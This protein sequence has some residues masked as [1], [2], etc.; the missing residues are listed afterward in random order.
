MLV[1]SCHF[2]FVMV[3]VVILGLADVRSAKPSALRRSLLLFLLPIVILLR[4][5]ALIGAGVLQRGEANHQLAFNQPDSPDALRVVEFVNHLLSPF[6]CLST[7]VLL[8]YVCHPY[9]WHMIAYPSRRTTMADER[10]KKNKLAE[11]RCEHCG[12]AYE[13]ISNPGSPKRFCSQ[14]CR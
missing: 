14:D 6:L 11:S 8:H 7:L 12:I 13:F 2:S 5:N 9:K 1:R 3:G 10:K 4:L